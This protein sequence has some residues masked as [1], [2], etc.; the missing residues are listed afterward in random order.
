MNIG[1][2]HHFGLNFVFMLYVYV[3]RKF[4]CIVEIVVSYVVY[5]V[6]RGLDDVLGILS[7]DLLEQE[8]NIVVVHVLGDV[9]LEETL[10]KVFEEVLD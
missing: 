10:V 2:A 3:C 1:C 9:V 5:D 4:F 7:R 8:L 6:D